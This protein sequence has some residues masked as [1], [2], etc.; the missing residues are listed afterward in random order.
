M[1]ALVLHD[2]DQD[3]DSERGLKCKQIKHGCVWINYKKTP[4]GDKN[5]IVH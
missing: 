3:N 4:T 1:K 5:K 2:L